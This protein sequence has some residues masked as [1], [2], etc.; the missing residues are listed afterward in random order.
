MALVT[1]ESQV[2]PK[3]R[4]LQLGKLGHA[5]YLNDMS[6][7]ALGNVDRRV[8]TPL[9]VFFLILVL[10]SGCG[11]SDGGPSASSDNAASEATES[12][13]QPDGEGESV[14]VSESET[15]P[16]SESELIGVWRTP[17]TDDSAT[18]FHYVFKPDETFAIY[19]AESNLLAMNGDYRL[20]ERKRE[21]RL[22]VRDASSGRLLSLEFLQPVGKRGDGDQLIFKR[23]SQGNALWL[24]RIS[25]TP[26]LQTPSHEAP[27]PDE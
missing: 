17:T 18:Q 24:H 7:R 19:R 9:T 26:R 10:V 11:P 15:V 25:E 6:Y 12:V 23:R 2:E 14:D 8:M 1:G 5:W 27:L 3:S 16:L 13:G 4:S 20:D 22:Y 21:L